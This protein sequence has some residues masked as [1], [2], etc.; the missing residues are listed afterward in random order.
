MPV[1]SN[2]IK[3]D[4]VHWIYHGQ[5]CQCTVATIGLPSSWAA[6]VV[7]MSSFTM[8]KVVSVLM[9]QQGCWCESKD[10]GVVGLS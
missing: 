10:A 8:D 4:I 9:L 2:C 7:G 5:G 6:V 1:L 3:Q